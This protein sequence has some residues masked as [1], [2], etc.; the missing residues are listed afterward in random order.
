MRRIS[1][2]QELDKKKKRNQLIVGFILVGVMLLSVLGY[3]FQNQNKENSN[4]NS[5]S[6]NGFTF[7]NQNDLWLTQ[8]GTTVLSFRYNPEQVEEIKTSI[9]PIESYSGKTVYIYSENKEPF[10][11]IY[12]NFQGIAQRISEACVQG[13]TCNGDFP[14]KNCTDNLIIITESNIS[15]ITQDN[16]CVRISSPE[17]NLTMTIDE[18]LFKIFGIRQ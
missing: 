12:R 18:F 8:K 14:V 15:K 11:E 17:E 13:E 3:S 5:I 1:S 4:P 7:I 16:N 6:Y 2:K 9:N 10:I